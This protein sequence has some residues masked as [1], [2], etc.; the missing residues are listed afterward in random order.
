MNYA[1]R[2]GTAIGS[3]T[4]DMRADYTSQAGTL[5]FGPGVT[6]QDIVI[7]IMQDDLAETDEEFY[8]EL[9]RVAGCPVAIH[10]DTVR[11]LQR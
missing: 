7:P 10:K 3:D 4:S 8:V 11:R 6:Q 9:S 5:T 2:D 1:T